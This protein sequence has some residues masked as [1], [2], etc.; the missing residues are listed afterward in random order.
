MKSHRCASERTTSLS[1]HRSLPI[2]LVLGSLLLPL[3]ELL[4]T[5]DE[6]RDDPP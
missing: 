5:D 2:S 3:E 6:T 1:P 4:E